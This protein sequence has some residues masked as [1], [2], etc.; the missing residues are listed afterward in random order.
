[1]SLQLK[2]SIVITNAI[3]C[4]WHYLHSSFAHNWEF[5]EINLHHC[6]P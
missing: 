5:M 1:L 2:R 4:S 3:S 6:T